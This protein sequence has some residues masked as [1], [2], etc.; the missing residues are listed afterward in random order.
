MRPGSY[1]RSLVA[2]QLG[3]CP[4]DGWTLDLGAGDGRVLNALG[5]SRTVALDRVPTPDAQVPFV[6]GDLAAAPFPDGAFQTILALDLLEHLDP[7]CLLA[8]EIARLAAP[9]ATVWLSVPTRDFRLFPHF[10]TS[11]VHRAWGHRRPGYTRRELSAVAPASDIYEWNEP[12]YRACYILI[13]I[14]AWLAAPLARAII[15]WAFLY[16]MRH[17]SGNR[18]HYFARYVVSRR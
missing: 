17:R 16:D 7:D 13:R 10:L 4:G 12:A 11:P 3:I 8:P 1:Y 14:V 6:R 15:Q 5:G 18:G 2:R 9:G